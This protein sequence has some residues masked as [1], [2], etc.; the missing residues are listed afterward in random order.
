MGVGGMCVCE[1][2]CMCVHLCTCMFV[3]LYCILVCRISRKSVLKAGDRTKE[4]VRH[5]ATRRQVDQLRT[6][7]DGFTVKTVLP[8]MQTHSQPCLLVPAV[9]MRSHDSTGGHMT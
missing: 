1:R 7:L 9:N 5:V 3:H 6:P 2:E 4:K 8:L